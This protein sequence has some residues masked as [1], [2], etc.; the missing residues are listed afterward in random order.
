MAKRLQL[1][2]G[3]VP[4][5]RDD[6]D[7]THD[8]DHVAPLLRKAGVRAAAR[9]PRHLPARVDLRRWCPP[10][11]FQGGY[12]TCAAHVVAGLLEFFEQKA[13]G[14]SVA[15][16]RLFLYKVSKNLLQQDGDQG[17]Y[18]RQAM[19]VLKLL[20]VPPEKY[21]PY[22][23]PG[24]MTAPKRSDPRLD[25]EPT[26]FC[27]ALAR[28]YRSISYYRLDRPHETQEREKLLDLIRSHLAAQIPLSVGFPLFESLAQATATGRIPYPEPGEKEV[29]NHAV[30]VVGYDDKL[31]ITN[32]AKGAAPTLGALLFQ[33]TWSEGWGE[34]GYGWLPYD[35]VL[36]GR[37][38][39]CW[40]L[41]KAGWIETGQ[42][43]IDTGTALA[44]GADE[45]GKPARARPAQGR[46]RRRP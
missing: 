15:A 18:L 26:S 31:T 8:H 43:Q 17:I 20:G 46:A 13:F 7:L 32:T 19:G 23:D 42:F 21:W 40:T 22:V 6:R 39:D 11:R 27:Y 5:P 10:V 28:D 3:W 45:G 4:D 25:A 1:G 41:L 38:R 29:G 34:G 36:D 2:T 35:F 24:T 16:S 9:R 37:A 33:N 30:M 44:R 12:N 14:K